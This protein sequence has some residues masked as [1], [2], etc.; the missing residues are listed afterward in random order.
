MAKEQKTKKTSEKEQIAELNDQIVVLQ[1]VVISLK[2]QIGGYKTSNENLRKNYTILTNEIERKE[3]YIVDLQEK[4][5]KTVSELNKYEANYVASQ[6]E[7]KVLQEK[8][9]QLSKRWWNKLFK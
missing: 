6:E 8:V 4:H 5:K 2:R 1:K 7:C 9:E 3:K